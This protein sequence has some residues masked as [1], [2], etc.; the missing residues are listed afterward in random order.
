[1]LPFID[2]ALLPYWGYRKL[3][4]P[5]PSF[6]RAQWGFMLTSRGCPYHCIFC[7][8]TSRQTIGKGF[9]AM[10]AERIAAEMR[11]QATQFG[12]NAVSFED[13]IFSLDQTRV[14]ELAEL[15]A[16]RGNKVPWIVQ[17][18]HDCLSPDLV[19]TMRRAG[20]MGISVGI[21]SGSNRILQVIRKD[22][23]KEAIR[24]TVRAIHATGMNLRLLFMIG[25]PTETREEIEETIA[26]ARELTAVT[27]QV[28]FC[29]PYPGTTIFDPD[30]PGAMNFSGYSDYNNL[31]SNLSAV[32]DEELVALHRRFYRAFYLSP[33]YLWLYARR[34]LPYLPFNA[35]HEW[36]LV[37]KTL[38]YLFSGKVV[39]A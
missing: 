24:E 16:S 3:S 9:H 5:V 6:R 4:F 33:K 30:R 36:F 10:S 7:S 8:P 21:E 34:R 25:N 39:N 29:T 26:F 27:M 38:A 37:K 23:S 35:G 31:Q 12:V 15:L 19:R 1:A 17:T 22:T 13:D 28:S 18:R 32:S 11:F 20:C 2:L 14:R